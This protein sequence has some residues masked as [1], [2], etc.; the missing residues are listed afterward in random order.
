MKRVTCLLYTSILHACYGIPQSVHLRL[1]PGKI[2][3]PV[4]TGEHA[5][6]PFDGIVNDL[7]IRCS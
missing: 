2:Q 4:A 5:L 1:Q 7:L 6:N 3:C